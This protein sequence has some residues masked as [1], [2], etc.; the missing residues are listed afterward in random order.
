MMEVRP[1]TGR[2]NVYGANPLDWSGRVVGAAGEREQWAC[3]VLFCVRL[4]FRDCFAFQAAVHGRI[5]C[6]W[7]LCAMKASDGRLVSGELY[8]WLNCKRTPETTRIYR[9]SDRGADERTRASEWDGVRI[10]AD[11]INAAVSLSDQLIFHIVRRL[12]RV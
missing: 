9:H 5:V 4:G 1:R 3:P 2:P 12:I 11:N 6:A 10:E 7:S 8:V